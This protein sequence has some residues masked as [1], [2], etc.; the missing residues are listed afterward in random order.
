M[1]GGTRAAAVAAVLLSLGRAHADPPPPHPTGVF[2]VE[3]RGFP[4]S[5]GQVLV[6]V[7]NSSQAWLKTPKAVLLRRERPTGHTFKLT[8]GPLPYGSY[9]V[10]VLH[11]R[12]ANDKMDMKW[13]PLPG[14]AEHAGVSRNAPARFGP[15]SYEDSVVELSQPTVTLLIEMRR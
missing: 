8:V 15:P 11:D 3:A 1:S 10:S 5:S 13:F 4:D 14:P 7:Y 2:E 9:A 12:N 6:A